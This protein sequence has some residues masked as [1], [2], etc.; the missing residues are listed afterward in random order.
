[1]ANFDTILNKLH[2]FA[3]LKDEEANTPII[4]NNKRNFEVPANYN[5]TIAHAGDVNSQIITF[6]LPLTSESHLLSKC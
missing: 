3:T 1:M 6:R 2:D 4:I 5:L